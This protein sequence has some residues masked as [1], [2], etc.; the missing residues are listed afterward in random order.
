VHANTHREA[1]E[2]CGR[3]VA[4]GKVKSH[5]TVIY[6]THFCQH[7]VE[8]N[9]V[10]GCPGESRQPRVMQANGDEFARELWKEEMKVERE[11]ERELNDDLYSRVVATHVVLDEASAGLPGHEKEQLGHENAKHEILMDCVGVGL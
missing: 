1:D 7:S 2:Q 8:M 4:D 6:V 5:R 3:S 11:R 10:D 9:A